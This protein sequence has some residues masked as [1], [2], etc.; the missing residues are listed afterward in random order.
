MD[1]GIV[2]VMGVPTF[3]GA[4]VGGFGSGRVPDYLL[5]LLAG[6]FVLWQGIGLIRLAGARSRAG[7]TH[8]INRS[9]RMQSD[10]RAGRVMVEG[11]IGLGV[12][13]LGGA[14][15]LILGTIRLPPMIRILRVH[16]P[17]AAGTNLFI[18]FI[19]GSVGWI[20]H[21]VQGQVDYPLLVSMG[22]SAMAGSYF[23]ARLT[24]RVSLDTLITTMGWVLLVAGGALVWQ[25]F[26]GWNPA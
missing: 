7:Q 12:G 17:I 2:L 8:V 6:L 22:S 1:K 18:G 11:G 25:A 20:G 10:F 14:V 19:M 13:L 3:A 4:F 24:G 23:G 15:G 26:R 16:L 21:A 5:V 9:E